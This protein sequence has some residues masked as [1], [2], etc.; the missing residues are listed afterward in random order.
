MFEPKKSYWNG[1]ESLQRQ[2][3]RII[4][5]Y[6]NGKTAYSGGMTDFKN[7]S[8]LANLYGGRRSGSD[9]DILLE[10]ISVK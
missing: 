8:V 9:G 7:E 5:R 4:T 3:M 10:E 1:E 6:E 2:W